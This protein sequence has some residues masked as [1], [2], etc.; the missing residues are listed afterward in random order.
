MNC[1]CNARTFLFKELASGP[2]GSSSVLLELCLWDNSRLAG[3]R[4]KVTFRTILAVSAKFRETSAADAAK[5]V[6]QQQIWPLHFFFKM[7][8]EKSDKNVALEKYLVSPPPPYPIHFNRLWI[9][10]AD[11]SLLMWLLDRHQ[12][13]FPNSPPRILAFVYWVSLSL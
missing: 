2:Q 4:A 5:A 8:V 12:L 13:D 3:F 11:H 6:I 7:E 10:V 9:R 1:Q